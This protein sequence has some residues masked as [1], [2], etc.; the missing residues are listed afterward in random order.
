MAAADL[1]SAPWFSPAGER[2]GRYLGVTDLAYNPSKAQRDQLYAAGFNPIANI[3]G[4]GVLLYGDTTYT[5]RP[6]AF[7]LI[8]YVAYSSH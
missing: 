4:F 1:A 2:R 8:T 5:R 6:P 3:P 7:D